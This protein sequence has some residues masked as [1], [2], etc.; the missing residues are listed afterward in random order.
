LKSA[1]KSE[2]WLIDY[3]RDIRSDPF[4]TSNRKSD[5]AFNAQLRKRYKDQPDWFHPK[6][7]AALQALLV[8]A[9][10]EVLAIKS[11]VDPYGTPQCRR[12]KPLVVKFVQTIYDECNA[13]PQLPAGTVI[14]FGKLTKEQSMNT[15]IVEARK[16]AARQASKKEE[17]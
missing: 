8:R 10:W 14:T 13:T 3:M 6:P 4:K 17:P 15:R 5:R 12:C 1:K 9:V 11:V 16:A 7:S 2:Q